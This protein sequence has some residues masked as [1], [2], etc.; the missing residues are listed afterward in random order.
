MESDEV[1][2]PL[3]QSEHDFLR[4][5]IKEGETDQKATH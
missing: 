3:D 4:Q 5:D 2:R 1:V